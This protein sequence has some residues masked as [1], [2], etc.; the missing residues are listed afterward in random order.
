M[1]EFEKQK[2]TNK[3][4]EIAKK[5]IRLNY[6]KSDSPIDIT[7]SKI[8]G[9]PAVPAEF[10]WPTYTG[11][12][13][14]DDNSEKKTR[15]LSFLAQINLK[16]ISGL[17]NNELLP[18]SGI[19]SFFYD[20]E[21]MTWG[22]DPEDKGSAQVFYFRDET[23]LQSG[24]IPEELAEENVVPEFAVEFAPHVRLPGYWD[25][26]DEL[27]LFCG[28]DIEWDDYMECREKAG[29]DDIEE[30]TKLFGYP[31]VI[32]NPMEE[33]CEACSRGFR[34]GNSEDFAAISDADRKDIEDKAKD[35]VLLFQMSTI[36]TEDYEL[37]FGDCGSI[38]FWIRKEDLKEER[39]DKVWLI[40]QCF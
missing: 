35:W 36:Q 13:C 22:F 1:N 17:D 31:D 3:F 9:K 28:K 29:G 16:D 18:K 12:I 11:V 20:L 7:A 30:I 38:Y 33:E 14:G 8:G 5:E 15:P 39:F 27:E 23:T 6:Q 2:L 40:L 10:E 25:K 4:L 32:Q 21:T 26:G 34:Q 24:D 19:L 37:M